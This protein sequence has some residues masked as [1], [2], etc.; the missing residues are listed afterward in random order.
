MSRFELQTRPSEDS[1][2]SL[3][4]K[5]SGSGK[6][7]RPELFS[8]TQSDDSTKEEPIRAK[9]C[10]LRKSKNYDGFGLVLKYQQQLH[11]IGE[12]EEAS[13]SYRAGLRENDVIIFV[14]KSNVEKLSH[15]DVKVMIRALTLASNQVELTVLSKLDIPK[16]KTLQEK[17][18]VDW[19]VMG[20]E[21]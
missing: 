18:L 15:D 20:L 4:S 5:N 14:G 12:V 21:K 1:A 11:V 13:P 9:L 2:V 7:R 17:G 8:I 19:S 3:L 6:S 16:Y 10:H